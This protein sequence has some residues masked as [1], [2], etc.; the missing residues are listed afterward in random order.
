[1]PKAFDKCVDEGGKIRTKRLSKTHY[2]RMCKDKNG[3]WHKG[4]KKKYKKV[5]KDKKNNPH[6][7]SHKKKKY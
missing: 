5:L 1:M 2:I 4:Y 3:K 6:N 7:S